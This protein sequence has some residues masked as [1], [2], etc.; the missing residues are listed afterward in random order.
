MRTRLR[1]EQRQEQIIETARRLFHQHCYAQVDIETIRKAAEL[2]RGGFYHHFAAKSDILAR[3]I[4]SEV[5][6]LVSAV[7]ALPL[8]GAAAFQALIAKG[9]VHAGNDPGILATIT[10]RDD[11]VVYLSHLE[12]AHE[13]QLRPL[14]ITMV[15]AGIADGH[16]ADVPADHVAELFLSINAQINRREVLGDWSPEQSRAFA[17]TA[18]TALG[19]L[20]D[21]PLD[22]V[23]RPD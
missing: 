16:F 11:R 20:L 17:R 14:L 10:Q 13:R 19:R 21:V 18:L 15:E 6:A 5:A 12:Q 9:A 7:T 2:S 23:L 1:P 22:H 8:T 3:I 4:D